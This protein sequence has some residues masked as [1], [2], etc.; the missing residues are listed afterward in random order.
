V[1]GNCIPIYPHYFLST[2][3]GI[4]FELIEDSRKRNERMP[5]TVAQLFDEFIRLKKFKV[6]KVVVLGLAFRGD[7]A[8]DR[9]SPTYDLIRELRSLGYKVRIHDPMVTKPSKKVK[10]YRSL[11]GALKGA[12]AIIVAVDHSAYRGLDER[13]LEGIMDV[14][15]I[16]FDARGI[17]DRSSFNEERLRVIGVAPKPEF[18]PI[19][20]D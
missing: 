3:K 17:L 11:K 7:V 1:G 13:K 4:S 9:N 15:P 16:I 18:E 5:K 14:K 2:I 6:E 8:D 10:V 19:P 20:I 12:Q